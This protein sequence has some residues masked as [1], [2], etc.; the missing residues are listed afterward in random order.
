MWS[1]EIYIIICKR[2]MRCV[3]NRRGWREI[4]AYKHSGDRRDSDRLEDC[5]IDA[6]LAC[7]DPQ[8]P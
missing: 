4:A 7:G 5:Y 3:E 1:Y 6:Q 2:Y 8:R